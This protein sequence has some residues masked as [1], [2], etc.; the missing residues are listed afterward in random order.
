[1]LHTVLDEVE[2]PHQ[3]LSRTQ[4]WVGSCDDDDWNRLQDIIKDAS[5]GDIST[6]TI[7]RLQALGN[8]AY[9]ALELMEMR[10]V[11]QDLAFE[12]CCN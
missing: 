7:S 3:L 11:N 12:P 1:M 8:L 10:I 9:V 4:E 6:L 5:V 2:H